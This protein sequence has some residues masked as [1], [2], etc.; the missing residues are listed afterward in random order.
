MARIRKNGFTIVELL[1]VVVVLAILATLSIVAYNG[2]VDRARA[3]RFSSA[4]DSVQKTLIAAKTVGTPFPNNVDISAMPPSQANS[5]AGY[6][7]GGPFPSSSPFGEGECVYLKVK[8]KATGQI[9]LESR[10]AMLIDAATPSSGADKV[11]S[12]VNQQFKDILAELP[13]ADDLRVDETYEYEEDG[14]WYVVE[15]RRRGVSYTVNVLNGGK[16]I[17]G[18]ILWSFAGEGGTCGRGDKQVNTMGSAKV[19]SCTIRITNF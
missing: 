5:V 3:S 16:T 15:H 8:N 1:I 9:V 4:V 17:E 6:C 18:Y 11:N 2:V 19:T 13:K 10:S 12:A 7:L 14:T